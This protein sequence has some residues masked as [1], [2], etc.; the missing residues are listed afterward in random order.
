M[1]RARKP[2]EVVEEF[3]AIGRDAVK[4]HVVFR[5]PNASD[6]AA[7]AEYAGAIVEEAKYIRMN[8][9]PALAEEKKWL[10]GYM[11]SIASCDAVLIMV[12]VNGELGG[13]ANAKKLVGNS[14]HVAEFGISLREKFTGMGIGSRLMSAVEK[15]C[16]RIGVEIIML[17]CDSC[18]ARAVHVYQKMGFRRFGT[19]PKG[20][21][22]KDGYHDEIYYYKKVGG[23]G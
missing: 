19:L 12:V 16:N 3:D 13:I 4:R 17:S 15:E 14:N 18:N 7:Q 1:A 9:K 8:K 2:G 23:G 20:S 6:A 5:Y 21:K 10:K 22:R 11:D